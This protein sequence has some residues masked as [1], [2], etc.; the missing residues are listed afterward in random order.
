[1]FRRAALRILV[2]HGKPADVRF[3]RRFATD[4][5][6][7]IR[8]EALRLFERFGTSHDAATVLELAD[9]VYS[10]DERRRAA[11]TALRLANKKDKLAVLTQL[12]TIRSVR[13]WAVERLAEILPDGF[14]VA[15][16]LLSADEPDVRLAAA[17]V[18]WS[19]VT[20]DRADRLLS[21]YMERR[22]FYNVVRA[23]DRRLYAADWLGDALP[24]A[25]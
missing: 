23:V 18:V 1:M 14:G 5:D 9:Q 3:A 12:R 13:V 15:L 20:P 10:D 22:Y 11:Q 8:V 24:I 19:L 7:D 16:E 25:A 21:I 4:D 6:E 2:E 17:D